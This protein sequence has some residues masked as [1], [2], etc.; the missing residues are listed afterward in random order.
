G[1]A[2]AA[3]AA[4]RTVPATAWNHTRR[5]GFVT[6]SHAARRDAGHH[7]RTSRKRAIDG[8]GV[9]PPW[10]NIVMHDSI[11]QLLDGYDCG[12]LTRRQLVCALAAVMTSVTNGQAAEFNAKNI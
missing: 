8:I 11:A 5:G 2:S 10:F 4:A 3:V 9:L 12:V 6:V 7:R 1:R